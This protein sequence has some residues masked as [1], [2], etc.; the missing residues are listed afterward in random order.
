MVVE[1]DISVIIPSN[2]GHHELLKVLNAV[3]AQTV[4]PLEIVIVDSSIERG[5]CPEVISTLCE[6][7]NINL[8]YEHAKSVFLPGHARNIGLGIA[9]CELIAFIDVETIPRN[10]WLESCLD[11]LTRYGVSGIWGSSCF[12]A[13]TYFEKLVR[14]GFYGR[15]PR[16]T[17]PGSIFRKEVFDKTGQFIEWVRAGEDTE[18]MLRL[19]LLKLNVAD[20]TSAL[21]DYT[22]L[23]GSDAKSLTSKWYR[24]YRTSRQLPHFFPQRLFLWLVLYPLMTLVAFNWNFLIADWHMESPLYIG[25]ITKIVAVLPA[26]VY[27]FVRGFWLPIHR[28]VG[29]TKLLPMRFLLIISVCLVADFVK[30]L[31][32]TLPLQNV[33]PK[34]IP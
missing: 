33:K 11:R 2:H 1:L 14:D 5:V 18:W 7:C 19:E 9:S 21:I 8:V 26:L 23:I 34:K 3:C 16:K 15:L 6:S 20:P 28:G 13:E 24:N 17:L 30:I 32:F 25:H 31:I 22:G 12:K 4:K 29:V 27:F 10:Y